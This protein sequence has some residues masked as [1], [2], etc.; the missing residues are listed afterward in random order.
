[1]GQSFT[2]ALNKRGWPVRNVRSSDPQWETQKT[3]TDL[4]AAAHPAPG[5]LGPVTNDNHYGILLPLIRYAVGHAL[6]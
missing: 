5:A 4:P 3:S 6:K 2:N 1:V